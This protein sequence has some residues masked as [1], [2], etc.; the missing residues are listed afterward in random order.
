MSIQVDPRSC[1]ECGNH[2]INNGENFK[3]YCD[4]SNPCHIGNALYFIAHTF[5]QQ[6]LHYISECDN[7][8]HTV[9]YVKNEEELKS[10]TRCNM[11]PNHE[12]FHIYWGNNSSFSC[13][14]N[15]IC[16]FVL[17]FSKYPIYY[18]DK[19]NG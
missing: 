9:R 10:I 11:Y 3:Y 18:S 2:I 4:M 6:S 19:G 8:S 7:G 1:L 14:P 17:H 5:Q 13:T 15:H 12:D 16:Y